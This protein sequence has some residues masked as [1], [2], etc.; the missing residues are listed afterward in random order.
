MGDLL[1]YLKVSGASLSVSQTH[2]YAEQIANA[3]RYL[4]EKRLV[5]RDLAAKNIFIYEKNTVSSYVTTT[6][7]I[8]V[9]IRTYVHIYVHV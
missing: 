6:C 5:H 9:Y 1:S 7:T 2:S 8:N 4:E 3:M